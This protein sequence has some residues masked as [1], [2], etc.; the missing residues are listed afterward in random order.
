MIHKIQYFKDIEMNK[1]IGI[2]FLKSEVQTF[3]GDMFTDTGIELGEKYNN[4]LLSRNKKYLPF[5]SN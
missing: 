1:T 3:L 5:N 4:N 2:S